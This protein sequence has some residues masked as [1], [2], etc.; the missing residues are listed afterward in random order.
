MRRTSLGYFLNQPLNNCCLFKSACQPK[1]FP[2]Q[3]FPFSFFFWKG[4]PASEPARGRFLFPGSSGA[5]GAAAVATT[6]LGIAISYPYCIYSPGAKNSGFTPCAIWTNSLS[7]SSQQCYTSRGAKTWKKRAHYKHHRTLSLS[8]TTFRPALNW[9]I[10]LNRQIY[11]GS[12][13]GKAFIHPSVGAK[14]SSA[15]MVRTF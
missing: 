12:N 3:R 15:N 4:F 1:L 8:L 6:K 5:C 10:S 13:L 2:M 11:F 9:L 7:W 14:L